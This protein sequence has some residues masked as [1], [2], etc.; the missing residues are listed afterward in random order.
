M[1]GTTSLTC[2]PTAVTMMR[3][4]SILLFLLA[5]LE[6]ALRGAW[7]ITDGHRALGCPLPVLYQEDAS[8]ICRQ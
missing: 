8:G 2:V 7:L 4:L 3:L 1:A 6:S 5:G